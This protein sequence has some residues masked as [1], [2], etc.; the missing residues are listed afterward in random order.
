MMLNLPYFAE[1]FFTCRKTTVNL[2]PLSRPPLDTKNFAQF[3]GPATLD[4]A[5]RQHAIVQGQGGRYRCLDPPILN[6]RRVSAGRRFS[7][8]ARHD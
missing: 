3:S 5:N 4:E 1:I 7:M 8:E 2:P 6:E